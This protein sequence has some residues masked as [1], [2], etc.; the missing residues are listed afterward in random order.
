MAKTEVAVKAENTYVSIPDDVY[1][2][3][4]GSGF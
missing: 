4:A 2:Q 3:D 1:S